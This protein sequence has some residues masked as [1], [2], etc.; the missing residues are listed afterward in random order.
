MNFISTA[1]RST[2]FVAA[3]GATT[4][5]A[6]GP[7]APPTIQPILRQLRKDASMTIGAVDMNTMHVGSLS[8]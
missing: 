4:Q 3:S 1:E 5:W 7:T 2:P 8:E 6:N